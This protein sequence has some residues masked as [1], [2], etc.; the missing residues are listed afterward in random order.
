MVVG[1][2]DVVDEMAWVGIG[3]G[4]RM[5]ARDFGFSLCAQNELSEE[6]CFFFQKGH[7]NAG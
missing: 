3:R 6:K 4:R 1:L 2:V 7:Q 5:L